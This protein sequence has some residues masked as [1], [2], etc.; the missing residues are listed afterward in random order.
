MGTDAVKAVD[1][2]LDLLEAFARIKEPLSLSELARQLDCPVSSCHGLIR[3]MKARG[4]LYRLEQRRQYYPTRRLLDVG[5]VIAAYDPLVE[6]LIPSLED[7]QAK[8]EETVILGHRQDDEIV[9]LHVLES[10]QTIRY[11]ASP[12]DRKPLHSSAL[13]KAFLGLLDEAALVAFLEERDLARV[14]ASTITE[15]A[16]LQADLRRSNRRGYFVTRGENVPDVTAVAR[17]MAV[18]TDMV[19][20]CV[21]GPTHRMKPKVRAIGRAPPR[22]RP[23]RLRV[24]PPRRRCRPTRS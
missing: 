6:R 18:E 22:A 11:A 15:A 8:T 16:E 20:V 19:G 23:W 1:R 10:P 21:A 12:G 24:L 9:Y 2:T 13:G 4:F 3:T 17:T 7:L 14:T 5:A